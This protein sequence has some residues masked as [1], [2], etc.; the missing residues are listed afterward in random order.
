LAEHRLGG[1]DA[2]TSGIGPVLD[3]NVP[4]QARVIRVGDV[5]GSE[6]VRIGGAQVL[7][8]DDAVVDLEVGR[9]GEFGARDDA[10]ANDDH[11][12]IDPRPV[13]EH[14]TGRLPVPAGQFGRR[15]SVA[16]VHTMA[17]VQVGKDG[18]DLGAEHML[19]RH[20]A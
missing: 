2:L 4:P 10:H 14:D 3:T 15:G 6:D 8:N 18:R 5:A 13:A 1:D 20:V 7:V 9:G 16:Q 12:G 11:V 19:Q 17:V